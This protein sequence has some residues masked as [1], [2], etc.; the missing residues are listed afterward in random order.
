MCRNLQV[1]VESSLWYLEYTWV[2]K[3]KLMRNSMLYIERW[4]FKSISLIPLPIVLYR[5]FSLIWSLLDY[6]LFVTAKP[7]LKPY[8]EI[9]NPFTINLKSTVNELVWV[10]H[11]ALLI[12]EKIH[13]Y[14]VCTRNKNNRNLFS[15][16]FSSTIVFKIV[17]RTLYMS[18]SSIG[19][20]K[21]NCL[22]SCVVCNYILSLRY[23]FF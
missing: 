22:L 20:A 8:N 4:V 23:Y 14:I 11:E 18:L 12:F 19:I 9:M 2:L 13:D 21:R 5:F 3:W 17:F 7:H 1:I 10:N 15:I 16:N 6:F